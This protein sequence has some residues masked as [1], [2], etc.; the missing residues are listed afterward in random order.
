MN[1]LSDNS[2]GVILMVLSM[3][4][5]TFNDA[6]MKILFSSMPLFQAMFLRS[7]ISVILLL[8]LAHYQKKLTLNL[9]RRDWGLIAMRTIGEIG[10]TYFFLTALM[11]MPLAN[12]SAL[13]QILPLAVTLAGV[14]FLG[15][16]IG[17][18]RLAAIIV[19]FFGVMLII[20]PGG[21]G[22]SIYSI[23]ALIAVAFVI[24]RDITARSLSK[25][26][27]SLMVAVSSA[28]GI[29]IFAGVGA[30]GVDWVEVDLASF[31]LLTLAAIFIFG[32][33]IFS[34]S[35]MRIGDIG[36]IA[37][38]RYTSLLW[39]ILLGFVFFGELLDPLTLLG[40]AIVVAMGIFSFYR[41]HRAIKKSKNSS[42]S[43]SS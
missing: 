16:K 30:I 11:N 35:V 33:Y 8:A 27:P 29:T 32:G 43:K 10:A 36:F 26:T 4:A 15:E 22:F 40:S 3:A 21:D 25:Q 18:R 39:S 13:L 34:V 31:I 41:E 9:P 7:I 14:V 1:K 17:I 19:G 2:R 24:L 38:F 23:Y 5:F 42:P 37:P 12:I 6:C 28:I 20:R